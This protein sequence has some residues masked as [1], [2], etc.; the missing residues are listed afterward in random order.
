MMDN[1]T[2]EIVFVVEI[3]RGDKTWR[4]DKSVKVIN[5]MLRR[6]GEPELR[7]LHSAEGCEGSR[8]RIAEFFEVTNS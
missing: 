7:D 6:F 2:K 4:L 1:F 5:L 8:I 3:T